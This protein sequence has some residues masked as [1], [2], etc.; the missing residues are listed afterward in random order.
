MAYLSTY[1]KKNIM[2]ETQNESKNRSNKI[3]K[4][5]LQAQKEDRLWKPGNYREP[6]TLW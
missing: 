6:S 1:W 4:I 3:L 2:D 5:L